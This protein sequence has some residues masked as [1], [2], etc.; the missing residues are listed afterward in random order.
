M[1]PAPPGI[2]APASLRR[3]LEQQKPPATQFRASPVIAAQ[4]THTK[5]RASPSVPWAA[6][7]A[8]CPMNSANSAGFETQRVW[9]PPLPAPAPRRVEPEE[10]KI[11]SQSRRTPPR[12]QPGRPPPG[13]SQR[14]FAE[15]DDHH[16]R[17]P[18]RGPA[19][20]VLDRQAPAK[21]EPFPPRFFR[22]ICGRPR[23][24]GIDSVAVPERRQH[25]RLRRSPGGTAGSELSWPVGLDRH[26]A[27]DLLG[28]RFQEW[29]QRSFGRKAVRLSVGRRRAFQY[30]LGRRSAVHSGADAPRP[31]AARS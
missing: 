10:G 26:A 22:R 28:R 17:R 23:P 31:T 16:R 11:R 8:A 4:C 15:A 3:W 12:D 30:S 18:D 5:I 14:P 25:G 9:L 20:A 13:G 27:Q 24:G 2:I 29:N 6:I 7:P 19:A 1:A 21:A